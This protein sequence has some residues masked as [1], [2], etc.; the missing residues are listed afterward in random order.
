MAPKDKGPKTTTKAPDEEERLADVV[1]IHHVEE[2]VEEPPS[3]VPP[4]PEI[5]W[6]VPRGYGRPTAHAM[7][8]KGAK[9]T[10]CGGIP[11]SGALYPAAPSLP[12][13]TPCGDAVKAWEKEW[14]EAHGE[15]TS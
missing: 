6:I 13:C 8:G 9:R 11:T 5:V 14:L 1:Q 7:I 10:A 4:K 2:D 3:S 15:A 12:R